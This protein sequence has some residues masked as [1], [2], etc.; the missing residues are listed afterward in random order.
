MDIQEQCGC[1]VETTAGSLLFRN[2]CLD[3]VQMLDGKRLGGLLAGMLDWS[4]V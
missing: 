4:H 2:R 3:S 1:K